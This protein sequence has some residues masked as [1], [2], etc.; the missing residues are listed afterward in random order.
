M[1]WKMP[2]G[3]RG[4][5]L[6][7]AMWQANC[8]LSSVVAVLAVNT[9]PRSGM[10]WDSG[11]DVRPRRIGELAGIDRSAVARALRIGVEMRLIRSVRHASGNGRTLRL[12]A[13]LFARPGEA[14]ADIPLSL[15]YSGRWAALRTNSARHLYLY[16]AATEGGEQVGRRHG[17]RR[18][19]G[20]HFERVRAGLSRDCIGPATSQLTSEPRP[21]IV[22]GISPET[23]RTW[24]ARTGAYRSAA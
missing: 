3:D 4:H 10:A 23:R 13:E 7:A 6:L 20:R 18:H 5:S 9:F 2:R 15:V 14:W 12:A 22:T 16:V 11:Q 8:S 19:D 1:Y 17:S 21:L 24:W